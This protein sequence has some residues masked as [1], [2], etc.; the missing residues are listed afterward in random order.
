L[1]G[2]KEV[3][4]VAGY[5]LQVTSYGQREET[6]TSCELHVE[7]GRNEERGDQQ[8]SQAQGG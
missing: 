3:K 2:R 5:T 6:V 7:K 8:L 1:K 4:P